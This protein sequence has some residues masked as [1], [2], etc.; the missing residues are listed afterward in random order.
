MLITGLRHKCF[1]SKFCTFFSDPKK[2]TGK[3]THQPHNTSRRSH[4]Y[5]STSSTLFVSPK[6]GG[7][8]Q[9]SG[10][11]DLQSL[12]ALSRTCKAHALD[13]L[14]LILLIENEITRSHGVSSLEEA[15][16]LL[17]DLF[18]IP[19][20]K[21]WLNRTVDRTDTSIIVTQDTM[22]SCAMK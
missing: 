11:L 19:C 8:L 20:L 16:D 21:Q 17:H 7:I 4:M 1:T 6:Q 13:E 15:I 9:S 5:P 14:S 2:K 3:Q 18:R 10:F 22:K 12:M